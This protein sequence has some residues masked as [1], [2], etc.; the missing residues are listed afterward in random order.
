MIK[1]IAIVWLMI[2]IGLAA[3]FAD[4]A[5]GKGH[6]MSY[7]AMSIWFGIAMILTIAVIVLS[8]RED[9]ASKRD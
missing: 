9:A 5:T 8:R 3:G 2:G 6:P 7:L 4:L 1:G